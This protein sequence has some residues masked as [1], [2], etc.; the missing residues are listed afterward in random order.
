MTE[1]GGPTHILAD[2]L[3]ISVPGR[4]ILPITLLFPPPH[5]QI[6]R[7]PWTL[8]A[9]FGYQFPLRQLW[10]IPSIRKILFYSWHL[11]ECENPPRRFLSCLILFMLDE[12]R[13]RH[14]LQTVL[15]P[16]FNHVEFSIN[17]FALRTFIDFA[18]A[19]EKI[20]LIFNAEQM[21]NFKK[22]IKPASCSYWQINTHYLQS[23]LG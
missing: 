16:I 7:H 8:I 14:I 4:A 1:S 20:P 21:F 10:M 23:L 2:Q 6:N 13:Y 12:M 11:N 18:K 19:C 22:L 5:F 9:F 17:A 3:T 15:W